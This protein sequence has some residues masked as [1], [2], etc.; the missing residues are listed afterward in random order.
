M[1][2]YNLDTTYSA[3][4]VIGSTLYAKSQVKALSL[5]YQNSAVLNTF[6][7][8]QMIGVVFSYISHPDG[9]YWQIE[10]PGGYFYV[11]H[12][13]G[14]F[15]TEALQEQGKQTVLEKIEAQEEA[16]TTTGEKL[17]KQL[18]SLTGTIK[19]IIIA[20]LILVV[21]FELNKKYNFISKFN[22]K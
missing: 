7:S 8:G 21:L 20:A 1:Y 17:S 4:E 5:P 12:L 13:P 14:N 15:S 6:R 10:K 18:T 16:T 19:W 11:L 9:L 2:K 3:D 22:T